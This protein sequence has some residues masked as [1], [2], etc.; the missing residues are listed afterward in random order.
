MT[1]RIIEYLPY[2]KPFLFVDR[3]QSVSEDGCIGYYT[4]KKEAYFYQGHFK[5]K[6]VTPGVLLTECMAQIGVVCLGIYLINKTLGD[7]SSPQIALTSHQMDFF[8]PVLPGETVKV[9]SKKDVFRFNKLKCKVYMYN[10]ENELVA[11][12]QISG[13]LSL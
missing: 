11:R 12:G 3:L 5:D 10:I 4:F 13:M 7:L 8:I 6:P 9:C 2:K 1:E